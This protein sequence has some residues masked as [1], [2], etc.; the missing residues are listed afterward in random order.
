MPDPAGKPAWHDL[1]V[2]DADAV[3]DFYASVLGMKVQ[4]VDMGG[5]SDYVLMN[6]SG[7]A[8]GICH[9]RG[10]NANLPPVWLVYFSVPEI[11]AAL[12]RVKAGGGEVVSG[13]KQAGGTTYAVIRDP[14]GAYAAI[15]EAKQG[16]AE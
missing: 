5:Y 1:T 15:A 4:P 10:S 8:I 2:D 3:R 12:E 7:D 13:P 16:T 11:D 14:A 9:R 6:D